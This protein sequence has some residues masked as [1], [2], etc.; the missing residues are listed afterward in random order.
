MK[1]NKYCY[2]STNKKIVKM[3]GNKFSLIMRVT[4]MIK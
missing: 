2:S 1:S 4:Y 3:E